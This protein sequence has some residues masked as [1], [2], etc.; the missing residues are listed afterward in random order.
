MCMR[1]PFL[2][3]TILL[4]CGDIRLFSVFLE[5]KDE[6]KKRDEDKMKIVGCD[7]I[8]NVIEWTDWP[9]CD[10][11]RHVQLPISYRQLVHW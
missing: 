5:L 9:V 8:A 2:V 6:G 3:E 7:S 1:M 4:K 11:P 10:V